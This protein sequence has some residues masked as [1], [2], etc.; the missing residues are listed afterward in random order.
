MIDSQDAGTEEESVI[1]EDVRR[2][3]ALGYTQELARRLG[4]FSN[5]A[6]SMSIICILAGGVTSFHL[7][8]CSVGGASI[9]LGWP[10]VGLFALVVASTM[11]QLASAFPTAGGLYHWASILGGRGWGWATAW[12][13][14]AGLVTV[15]A[16]INVGTYEFAVGAFGEG[17]IPPGSELTA[18]ILGVLLITASQA[19]INH[20]GI[21]ATARL[22]DFSGYWILFISA[23]LTA[24]FLVFAPGHDP[25]RL[26]TFENFSGPPGGN[27]WPLT[28]SLPFLFALGLLLPAYTITGFDASAHA[29]E[30]TVGAAEAVPRGIIRSVLVS[31][32]A[33]WVLL[34]SAVLAAPSIPE[35]A[36]KGK[37]AFLSIVGEVIPGPLATALVASIVLAQYLC[38][39]ATVTSASRMAFAFARD[40][41]L[42]FSRL[43]RRVSPRRKS[44]SVAIW[45]VSLASVLF[46]VYTPVY[47][48]ITVVC[49]IFLYLSY[50]L[51]TALGA[52]AYG[53]T[54]TAMGP[55]DMGRWYRPMAIASVLGCLALIVIG[56]QPPNE[57]SIWVVGGASVV[58]A[59]AWLALERRRFPG[60][61][62]IRTT[63]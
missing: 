56:M 7:G 42:P 47:S 21:V 43:V 11:G 18:Q 55:W 10:L 27:T 13:N 5:F 51:P 36:A 32:I 46:T 41:G 24:S 12:F 49:T 31:G 48:T 62:H 54:W 53:R 57:Q 61:P 15:L 33:G 40:G 59:I 28:Q 23:A 22:T 34:S 60:P 35:A 52:R 8:I 63:A 2:L 30:E 16:A 45:T 20:L 37:G 29:S 9:G 39:L 4:S 17:L 6:I 14:L 50:V 19:A 44:P 25:S 58:L 3:H 1:S 26:V 38:G